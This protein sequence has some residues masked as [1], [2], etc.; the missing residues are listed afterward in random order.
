[1]TVKHNLTDPIYAVPVRQNPLRNQIVMPHGS[2]AD[3]PDPEKGG[4]VV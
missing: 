4:F 2:I 3:Y 1:M